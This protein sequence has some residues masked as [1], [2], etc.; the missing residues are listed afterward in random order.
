MNTPIVTQSAVPTPEFSGQPTST[1]PLAAKKRP[2]RVSTKLTV[3]AP[4]ASGKSV[5][6]DLA[7]LADQERFLKNLCAVVHRKTHELH[8]E[9]K[10]VKQLFHDKPRGTTLYGCAS[11]TDYCEQKLGI[12]R[13]AFYAEVGDY[14]GEQKAKK[15]AAKESTGQEPEIEIKSD[16]PKKYTEHERQLMYHAGAA[17]AQLVEAMESGDQDAQHRLKEEIK[18]VTDPRLRTE[19]FAEHGVRQEVL[20]LKRKV[21]ELTPLETSQAKMAREIAKLKQEHAKLKKLVLRLVD[22]IVEADR[23]QALPANLMKVAASIRKEL[24]V[25]DGSL[26]LDAGSVQ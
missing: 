11:V 18:M 2:K 26:G 17:G 21:L 16:P 14:R 1:S 7:K 24:A 12:T 6:Y 25:D 22:E 9:L 3:V 20:S 13:Q 19:L 5:T 15:K 10:I 23:Y 8:R 4:N